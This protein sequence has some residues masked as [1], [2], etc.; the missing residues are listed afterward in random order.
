VKYFHLTAWAQSQAKWAKVSWKSST[1]DVT[2]KIRTPQPKNVCQSSDWETCR[3]FEPL[4]SSLPLSAP[5]LHACK[6]TCDPVVLV[7]DS[8][9]VAGH[10]SVKQKKFIINLKLIRTIH[11]VSFGAKLAV[12]SWRLCS[13]SSFCQGM[14]LWMKFFIVI[15]CS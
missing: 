14:F 13:E 1:Y 2:Q 11:F 8:P 15:E 6:A 7:R 3:I 4:N 10:E 12:I 5:E 9:K